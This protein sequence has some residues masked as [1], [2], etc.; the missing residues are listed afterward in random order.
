MPFHTIPH[1]SGTG[2]VFQAFH[3]VP[4]LRSTVEHLP[5]L[6]MRQ[7]TSELAMQ[8]W[9]THW[10]DLK[11]TRHFPVTQAV[12]PPNSKPY[13]LW[14]AL[15]PRSAH[16]TNHSPLRLAGSPQEGQVGSTPYHHFPANTPLRFDHTVM[17]TGL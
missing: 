17:N 10:A 9:K 1:C 5:L 16:A 12:P 3:S 15:H 14:S 11:A 7:T 6:Q 8:Q 13:P 2:Q 4:P